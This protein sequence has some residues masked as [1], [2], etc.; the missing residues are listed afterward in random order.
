MK[1]VNVKEHNI[2][3][4]NVVRLAGPARTCQD[5]QLHETEEL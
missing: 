3:I 1:N 5:K 2:I 4:V